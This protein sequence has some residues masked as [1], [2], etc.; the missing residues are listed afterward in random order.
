MLYTC[1]ERNQFNSKLQRDEMILFKF[2]GF[3]DMYDNDLSLK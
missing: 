3:Y 2:L 1:T